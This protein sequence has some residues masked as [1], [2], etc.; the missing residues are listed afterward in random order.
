MINY[1]VNRFKE[2]DID[3]TNK[4]TLKCS[5]CARQSF[6]HPN[7]IPG[8][9]ASIEDLQKILDYFDTV[10]LCG[11]YGDPIFSPNF[12]PFLKM[13]HEQNKQVQVH[14]CVT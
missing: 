13:C 5:M 11:T 12:I 3:L 4:C 9:D 7:Q 14:G 8:G 1:K 2:V 10:Y 6:E